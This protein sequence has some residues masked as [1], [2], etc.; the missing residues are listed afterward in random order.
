MKFIK[1]STLYIAMEKVKSLNSL[2]R[3][4]HEALGCA[5]AII[6]MTFFCK[7]KIFPLLEKL[8]PSIIPY[9]ITE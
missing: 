2:N 9:F 3:H 7:A 5:Q 8:P 1:E 6:M 4:L